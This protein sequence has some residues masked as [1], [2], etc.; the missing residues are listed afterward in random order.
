MSKIIM[1]PGR[2]IQGSGELKKIKDHIEAFGKSFLIIGTDRAI[3][4][5]T[6]T[7]ETSFKESGCKL[8]YETFNRECC[9]EEI[10]R[11]MKV[12]KA[13]SCDVIVGVGGG[14]AFDTAKAVAYYCKLPVIIVPTIAA[15]DAPCSALSVIYTKEGVFSNYLLLPKNPEV[16]LVDTDI[17]AE[18]P[19]RLLVAG[20]GDALAT[21]FEARACKEGNRGNMSGEKAT[22]AAMALA[23]LCYDTLLSDGVQA[24]V[25]CE[26]NVCT[27]AVENI[28]E[29]NTYLSG[30]GFES[31][32]L[33]AA[34][35][36]HDGFTVLEKTH[37]LYHGEK[38]AFGA[39]TELVLENRPLAEIEEA[40]LFC[41]SVGLPYTFS[42]LGV[43]D[44]TTKELM[45][46]AVA[47]CGSGETMIN[48]PF[49]VTPRDVYAALVA[50]DALGK[51]YK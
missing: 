24:M 41:K 16:V 9:V 32:G 8:S 40:I 29:A 25:A 38:V 30:I 36:I 12:V 50:T 11:L 21:Y 37:K 22:L 33:A 2:Y 35:A 1:S 7:I 4:Q 14:K 49:V 15:T 18:A 47:S 28:I 20:M 31:G 3:K 6:S 19:V 42:D 27:K 46:V 17:V 34:H 44:A 5:T 39:I 13:S 23:K 51:M 10:E 26:G 43:A 45:S 48:E